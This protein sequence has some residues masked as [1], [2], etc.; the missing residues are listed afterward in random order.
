[1]FDR[2]TFA[3]YHNANINRLYETRYDGYVTDAEGKQWGFIKSLNLYEQA[4]TG[5]RKDPAQF[6]MM[7]IQTLSDASSSLSDPS[8]GGDSVISRLPVAAPDF[9]DNSDGEFLMTSGSGTWSGL[10]YFN[11]PNLYNSVAYTV[12][13]TLIINFTSSSTFYLYEDFF[14]NAEID[15]PP[16]PAPPFVSIF[17]SG[18]E[19][20][21]GWYIAYNDGGGFYRFLRTSTG[22]ASFPYNETR[23]NPTYMLFYAEDPGDPRG[24]SDYSAP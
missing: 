13:Q 9:R 7:N 8:S 18:P 6:Q 22:T 20:Y 5:I 14:G 10:V 2:N 3:N 17:F 11:Y 12:N 21:N 16:D 15:S 1:M 19:A 24:W 23:V 4:E